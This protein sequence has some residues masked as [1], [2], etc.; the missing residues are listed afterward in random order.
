MRPLTPQE[1][2]G[3]DVEVV[4]QS[5]VLVDDLDAQP[6]G[7]PRPVDVDGLAFEVHLPVV[8]GVDP[9]HALDE[10]R[11]PRT[12]VPHQRHH[13]A[14]ADLEV[15]AVQSLY[16]AECLRDPL[17]VEERF[18]HEFCW[19]NAVA[20]TSPVQQP[21]TVRNS[22]AITVS[23]TLS[24]VTPIGC[25]ATYI[26]APSAESVGSP[27]SVSMPMI[28]TDDAR[29]QRRRVRRSRPLFDV[30]AG[31]QGQRHRAAATPASS[32]IGL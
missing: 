19:Q 15:D 16:R 17:A 32:W 21:S 23:A 22:S 30:V 29:G 24:T 8:E 10:R 5:K 9:H 12:V 6:G 28:S 27:V 31:P 7:V 2:V 14:A 26:T 20:A 11:L 3:S 25:K 1:H 13:L 18:C 4:G